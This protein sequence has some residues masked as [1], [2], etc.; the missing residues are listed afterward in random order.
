MRLLAIDPGCEMSAWVVL[1]HGQPVLHNKTE[2][3]AVLSDLRHFF[4]GCDL[5]AI[6]MIASYGMAVGKEVFDT[7][8]WVGRFMEAWQ[9]RGREVRLIYRKDVKLFH[10]DTTRANDS[11]IRA[12]IIDRFG[13]KAAAIGRK[14]A[15]GPLYG[16]TA[17]RWSAL[18][19]GLMVAA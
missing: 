5:L 18:A 10:C 7:C 11:N 14:A 9:N 4:E 3:D 1:E 6:E 13:G 16:I 19:L 8:L 17:D 12:S 2:N 15:P